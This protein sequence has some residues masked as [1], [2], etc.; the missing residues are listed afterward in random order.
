MDIKQLID[1]HYGNKNK[2]TIDELELIVSS[3]KTRTQLHDLSVKAYKQCLRNGM[4]E[5][6]FPIVKHTIEECFELSK[7]YKTRTEFCRIEGGA[8]KF[9]CKHGIIDKLFPEKRPVIDDSN[10]K[11]RTVY[12]YEDVDNKTVYIGFSKNITKR[13]ISNKCG[14]YVNGIKKNS[15]IKEYFINHGKDLPEYKILESNLTLNDAQKKVHEW[16]EIYKQSDWIILN[17]ETYEIGPKYIGIP[18]IWTK[19]K[20]IEIA[21]E[22]KNKNEMMHKYSGAY[23]AAKR[24]GINNT[25]FENKI[26]EE[27]IRKVASECRNY[28]HFKSTRKPYYR[29]AKEL[30]LLEEL[31]PDYFRKTPMGYWTKKDNVVTVAKSCKTLLEFRTKFSAAYYNAIK[32]GYIRELFPSNKRCP[33]M[34]YDIRE[35]ENLLHT[36]KSK[37]QAQNNLPAP[38]FK[39]AK[40]DGLLDKCFPKFKPTKEECFDLAKKYSNKSE[41]KRKFL[42]LYNRANELGILNELYPKTNLDRDRNIRCIYAYEDVIK[43]AVYVGLTKNIKIRHTQHNNKIHKTG[44]YDSVKTWFIDHE[45]ELP[46]YKILENNLTAEEAQTAEDKWLNK[47]Y[48]NGWK[49]INRAKTGKNISSIG[50]DFSYTPEMVENLAK[51]CKTRSEFYEKY[52]RPAQL[53]RKWGIM[54]EVFKKE[55]KWTEEVVRKIASNCHNIEECRKHHTKA[56]ERL[57][58]LGLIDVYFPGHSDRIYKKGYKIDNMKPKN[59]WTKDNIIKAS[60]M[61]ESKTEFNRNY[62]TAYKKAL[63][64]GYL[65]ELFPKKEKKINIEELKNWVSQFKTRTEAN[66]KGSYPKFKLA[67]DLG[68]VDEI[69]P[70]KKRWD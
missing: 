64:D 25:L 4:I 20:L 30:G 48:K 12:C 65:N 63:K 26:N 19:E 10:E 6:Y 50:S 22:C 31:F 45:Q 3:V 70:K 16:S 52:N 34:V 7:K 13:H 15:Y 9:A 62:N 14:Q 66:R 36:Y 67:L 57:K 23:H 5:K 18:K 46:I 39:Q 42:K 1:S 59:Y 8:Y 32:N 17:K 49:I 11:K 43:N 28:T 21:K 54:D 2:F 53:A 58:E 51:S 37:T 69:L 38:I 44:K 35:I 27:T 29:K 61:C 60:K 41:L 40:E 33:N 24:L 56:Y 68:I 47:Y 55:Y